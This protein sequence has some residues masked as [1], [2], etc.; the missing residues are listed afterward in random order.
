MSQSVWRSRR[1]LPAAR[2]RPR[3]ASASR[4]RGPGP[5][6]RPRGG[7]AGSPA[8][9]RRPA[10]APARAAPRPRRRGG[11]AARTRAGPGSSR[12]PHAAEEPVEHRQH[13]ALERDRRAHR[14]AGHAD[15][16]DGPHRPQQHRV[17]R[18]QRHAPHHERPAARDHLARCGRASPSTSPRARA[19]S[20]SRPRRPRA[21]P[22]AASGS[23]GAIG[24]TDRRGPLLLQAARRASRCWSPPSRPARARCP[25]SAARRPSA[26]PRRPAPRAPEASRA[27]T[28][29]PARGRTAPA[30]RPADTMRAPAVHV[31][32]RGPH[33]AAR[34]RRMQHADPVGMRRRLLHRH[35]R[36]PPVLDALP[37]VDRR[38]LPSRQHGRAPPA[39]EA[40]TTAKPVHRRAAVRRVRV[41][42]GDVGRGDAAERG[43]E[44]H[45]LAAGD[46]SSAP[47]SASSASHALQRLLGRRRAHRIRR[48][49][50][51]VP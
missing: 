36:V 9:G 3:A 11:A 23:S 50:S 18:A 4:P 35:D 15:D 22:R 47:R 13:E 32:A 20:A 10:R 45:G 16:G 51:S 39:V 24:S 6:A 33:V 49:I 25:R 42:G 37:G 17:R 29:P 19:P 2:R 31:L 27:R 40:A 41:Q 26:A 14:I 34:D 12:H 5:T 43:R 30:A 38:E 7:S 21:P 28:P 1:C 8:A 44:R 48:P 46:G